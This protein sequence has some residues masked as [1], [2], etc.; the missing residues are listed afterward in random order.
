MT[1]KDRPGHVFEALA[2]PTRREVMRR[3]AEDGPSS[4]THLASSLPVTRQAVAKHLEILEEA[5]LVEG[6]RR[7]RQ[8]LFR[9]TPA[10]LSEAV[11]WMAELGSEWDERLQAL[12]R[13]LE[14]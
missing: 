2:D 8:R 1:P 10:P 12:R 6:E 5:G 7:G 3:L 9:L 14:T 13:L 11:G 4:A